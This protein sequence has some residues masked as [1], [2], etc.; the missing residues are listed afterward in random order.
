MWKKILRKKDKILNESSV[1][2]N[3]SS[4]K[5]GKAV[6]TVSKH[7]TA[8][9]PQCQNIQIKTPLEIK[10]EIGQN[11]VYDSHQVYKLDCRKK[12]MAIIINNWMF[13]EIDLYPKR[14]GADVDA[15]NLGNLFGQLGFDV[16]HRENMD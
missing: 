15:V 9:S 3:E 4:N 6:Q 1:T 13:D 8:S 2:M 14:K 11:I 12:G 10:V 5:K 7:Q 16:M